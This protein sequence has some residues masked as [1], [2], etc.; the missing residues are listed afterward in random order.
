MDARPRR[1]S[2]HRDERLAGTFSAAAM[3]LGR[4][5]ML[6]PLLLLVTVTLAGPGS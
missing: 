6:P 5:G 3:L 1:S 4:Q 2:C